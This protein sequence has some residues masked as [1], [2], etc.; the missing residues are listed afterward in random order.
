MSGIRGTRCARSAGR[1]QSSAGLGVDSR[2][3]H[4]AATARVMSFVER[5]LELRA[6]R[7]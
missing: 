1:A 6:A 5:N 2:S 3:S 4:A 7:R